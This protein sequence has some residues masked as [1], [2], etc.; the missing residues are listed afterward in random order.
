MI[1]G[2]IV[3]SPFGYSCQFNFC[4]DHVSVTPSLI[5]HLSTDMTLSTS[6]SISH[7]GNVN[8]QF[9]VNYNLTSNKG[10]S[11]FMSMAFKEFSVLQSTSL[12]IV[13]NYNGYV[14]KLPVTLCD[15]AE[16]TSGMW[17]SGAIALAANALVYGIYRVSKR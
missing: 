1:N 5:Y 2:Q 8:A 9:G 10:A 3:G 12:L 6:T 7:Q 13:L 17:M 11:I 4:A 16:N 15:D 14:L